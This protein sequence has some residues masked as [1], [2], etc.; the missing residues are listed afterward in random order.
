MTNRSM[1]APARLSRLLCLGWSCTVVL[2]AGCGT[3]PRPDR[4]ALADRP[5]EVFRPEALVGRFPPD[6]AALKGDT[7][8]EGAIDLAVDDSTIY[9]VDGMASTVWRLDL[10]ARPLA[11]FGSP[12]MGP[13]ELAGPVAVRTGPDGSVWVSQTRASRITGFGPDGEPLGERSTPFPAVNLGVLAD[14]RPIIPTM[15]A[16]SLFQTVDG[17]GEIRELPVR[18]GKVPDRL[19][20]GPAERLSFRGLAIQRLGSGDLAVLQN[21]QGS[22]FSLWRV[23]L[24]GGGI[25]EL[26]PIRLPGWLFSLLEEETDALRATLSEEFAT[27]DFMIPFNGLHAVG[28]GLWLAPAPSQRAIAVSVPLEPE[29]PIRVVVR[30]ENEH[31]GLIDAAVVGDRLVGL[32]RTEVRVYHLE[33]TTPAAFDRPR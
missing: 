24:E 28:D 25:A 10:D 23:R 4:D 29:D 18:A 1:S 2:S 20:R 33:P 21:R 8:L 31:V 15:S 12:G 22:D 11:R 17:S 19:R 3:S 14:G 7:L 30:R 26:D 32:Y 13:G 6:P 5:V 27:G 9:V 16:A